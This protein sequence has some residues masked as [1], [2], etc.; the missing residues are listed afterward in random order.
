LH[1]TLYTKFSHNVAIFTTLKNWCGILHDSTG[2]MMK[3][4]NQWCFTS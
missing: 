3:M 4:C 1:I 2:L